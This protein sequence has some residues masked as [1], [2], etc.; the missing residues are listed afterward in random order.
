MKLEEIVVDPKLALALRLAGVRQHSL[1]AWMHN[2]PKGIKPL[3]RKMP[4]TK[5]L[6]TSSAFTL[7]ELKDILTKKGT[8]QV[9]SDNVSNRVE[10]GSLDGGPVYETTDGYEVDAVAK[11]ILEL[12]KLGIKLN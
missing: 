6:N 5:P 10:W 2:N 3:L 9:R 8:L 12:L 7:T 11:M 1:Y 4:L